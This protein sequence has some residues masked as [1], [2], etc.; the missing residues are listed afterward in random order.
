MCCF[1]R[2]VDRVDNTR[3]FARLGKHL[4]QAIIY[5]MAL[6]APQDVAMILPIPVKP[7]SGEK[8]VSFY[9]FQGYRNIFHDLHKGFPEMDPY[10]TAAAG[11]FGPAPAAAKLE[12]VSVGSYDASYVPTVADF[13]RLDERF[14]LPDQVWDQLPGYRGFAFVVFKLKLDKGVFHSHP[15]A[16][17]FPSAVPNHLFFPT[18]HI[19][20][21]KVHERETFDHTLYC[22][23]PVEFD[24]RRWQESPKLAVTFAKC[25]LT[26]G[27]VRPDQHVYRQIIR[28]ESPNTDI[29]VKSKAA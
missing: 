21:G 4:N 10:R 29:I 6:S 17:A 5:E 2:D 19:H 12:V 7:G 18:L 3:I 14:R 27:M 11:T 13:T 20:D 26:H 23:A 8:A 15:M 28:G 9:D 1:S 24:L 16:F 22:Q 25:G